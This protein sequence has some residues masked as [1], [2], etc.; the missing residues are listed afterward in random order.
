MKSKLWEINKK[1]IVWYF[2]SLLKRPPILNLHGRL[3][4]SPPQEGAAMNVKSAAITSFL[5]ISYSCINKST[6]WLKFK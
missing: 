4:Q 2:F 3:M 5:N 1:G 6:P